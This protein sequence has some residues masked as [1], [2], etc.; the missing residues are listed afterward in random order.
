MIWNQWK[1]KITGLKDRFLT[2]CRTWWN[3]GD[4]RVGA[5]DVFAR[6]G[7]SVTEITMKLWSRIK[8]IQI[9][10]SMVKMT[11]IG[12]SGT[13][14]VSVCTGLTVANNRIVIYE[15]DQVYTRYTSYSD[16]E[17]ILAEQK[18]LIGANDDYTFSGFEENE[19][20]LIIKHA[21]PVMVTADGQSRLLDMTGGTVA[22]ALAQAGITCNEDDLIN[23]PLD[24]NV[25][26]GSSIVINRVTYK[27]FE[28]TEEI[29]YETVR[30]EGECP[31]NQRETKV[32]SGKVGE[33]LVT[34]QT[35]YVDGFEKETTVLSETVVKEPV[36]E[37]FEFRNKVSWGGSV[38]QY[39]S[40][41]LVLDENGIPVN[42]KYKITG[43]ATAYSA[44]GKPTK[45]VPGCVAMD[46]SRFPKGTKLYIRTPS[47]SYVY[48]Y[49][50]VAD[51]GAFV[52]NG[53]GVLVDLFFNTYEESVRFGA[54]TVDVYVLE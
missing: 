11:A 24:E 34:K 14:L 22:D 37:V 23:V 26:S 32:V 2:Q 9:S 42:Y 15:D 36:T 28:V 51:T 50:K 30:P 41:D 39:D 46:L 20:E 4:G 17:D 18:I 21:F 33:K 31:E 10:K 44:L 38:L 3:P 8:S 49:S 54:K 43:K 6:I 25:Q 29:P 52:S 1:E 47:G 48:G 13:A 53:S 12:L 45:L 5:E 35:R 7:S 40:D 16:L 27:T 19:G